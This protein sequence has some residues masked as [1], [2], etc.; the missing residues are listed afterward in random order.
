MYNLKLFDGISAYTNLKMP[1]AT[2][3]LRLYKK[4]GSLLKLNK[5][6]EEKIL[7]SYTEN[8][9]QLEL[10]KQ[11]E[12]NKVIKSKGVSVLKTRI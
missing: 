5:F 8:S 2:F 6:H 4:I 7:E 10:I 12:L 3:S 11:E 1:E 9:A